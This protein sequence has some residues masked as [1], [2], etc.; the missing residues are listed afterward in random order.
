MTNTVIEISC[1]ASAYIP[2]IRVRNVNQTL[3]QFKTRGCTLVAT[4]DK[5]TELIYDV[6]LSGPLCLVMGNEASGVR[7]QTMKTAI[8]SSKSPWRVK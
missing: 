8:T 3:E 2:V 5:A 1:G 6:D 7:K 4:S